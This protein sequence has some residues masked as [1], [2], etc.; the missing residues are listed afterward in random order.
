MKTPAILPGPYPIKIIVKQSHTIYDNVLRILKKHFPAVTQSDITQNQSKANR[1][2]SITATVQ[3][4]D[5]ESLK[6]LNED[7]QQLPEVIMVL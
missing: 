6:Q 2:V 4:E 7:L 3:A 1:Y 5:E